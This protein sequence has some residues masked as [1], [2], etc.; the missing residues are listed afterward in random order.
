MHIAFDSKS[1]RTI[2]EREA[3]AARALGT[4][5]A[6]YLRHRLADLRAATSPQDLLTGRPRI[7]DD[8]QHMILDLCDGY[9]IDFT[10]NHT[11]NP[12]RQDGELDWA[13]VTRIKILRIESDH[14]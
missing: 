14:A 6:E 2:C 4:R 5:V 12:K 9:R 7:S 13:K 3:E 1:L 8:Q 11:T 10:A